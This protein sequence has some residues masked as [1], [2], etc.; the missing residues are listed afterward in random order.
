MNRQLNR[1]TIFFMI[2]LAAAMLV[3]GQDKA[4]K[5][6]T[7]SITDT[8]C[9]IGKLENNR[10][11]KCHA[12]AT[13]LENFMYGTKLSPETRFLKVKLQKKLLLH[14]WQNVSKTVKTKGKHKPLKDYFKQEI[15]DVLN[16]SRKPN[17]DIII[18]M[19][20]QN[21]LTLTKRDQDHYFSVAYALR[22]ILAL[23][24]DVMFRTDIN[25]VPL[26]Q[27]VIAPLKEFIDIFTLAVLQ[28]GDRRARLADA[29]SLTPA[30]F[31]KAWD[32][33]Q[34]SVSPQKLPA[35]DFR[36]SSKQPAP[37]PS[38]KFATTLEIINQKVKSYEA[39]N[40]ITMQV[41]LRNLQVYFARHQW[42]SDAEEGRKFR[43]FFTETM[44]SFAFEGVKYAEK[45]AKTK[46][47]GFIREEDVHEMWNSFVPFEV[48]QYEDVIFFPRLGRSGSLTIEA[49]DFDAF[50]D[51]GIHWRYLQFA[52]QDHLNELSIEPDPFAG[53]LLVEGIA[54]FGVLALRMAGMEAKAKGDKQLNTAH[55]ETAL[56]DIRQRVARHSTVKPAAKPKDI[57]ASSANVTT[58]SG[59]KT[60]FTDITQASGIGFEHRSSD[61]LSRMLRSYLK[62]S[63][64]VGTLN[65]PPAFGGAGAAA[66]DVNGDGITDVLLL[67]G[68]G[69][70]LYQGDGKGRFRDITAEAGIVFKRKDGLFGEPRQPI[71]ADFDNDGRQDILITYVQDDHKLYRNRGSGK[72]EDVSA[73]SNLGGKDLVGGPATAFDYDNDGLL[74]IYIAYF[75]DYPRGKLPKLTR[76][77]LNALP[78]KLFRNLGGMRFEDVTEK[79]GV[80]NTGWGQAL[81]H[82]DIDLDGWQDII[83]GNDFGVNVYYRNRG[84]GTFENVASQL[85]TDKPSFTM[86]V[87]ITDLNRDGFPDIYISNIVTMV[88]DEKYV[89]PAADTTMRSDP[90]KMARMRV[91]EANDLFLSHASGGK[92]ENYVLS[93]AVGRGFSSTGWAWGANFFDFD[94]DGDDDLYCVNGMNEYSVYSDTPYYTKVFKE[95][96]EIQ[97]KVYQKESNVFFVNEGG[98]LRNQSKKSGTDLLGNSRSTVYVD[99]DNDGDLDI[100]L[101][102][103]HGPAVVYRNNSQ[104]LGNNWLKVKLVGDPRRKTNRD[105]IGAKIIAYKN[106]KQL[107][108][109]EIRGGDGYLNVNPKVQHMGLGKEEVVDIKVIWPNGDEEKFKGI[110]ANQKYLIQQGSKE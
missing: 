40:K 80:G 5:K 15:A 8:I 44:V 68:S 96:R 70:A 106:D 54:Q 58:L 23:Q 83:V 52:L 82:T 35:S 1:V 62:K 81:G 79:A 24:Q 45:I 3:V 33:V 66:G 12:T 56:R 18:N 89:L 61:W 16:Y 42:P 71:I 11:P 103:Y 85:G 25:L 37:A 38:A 77:N 92:F 47:H 91:V 50:R 34:H 32:T 31:Q 17:G 46:K 57:L 88:K 76:D 59:G 101:N 7:K 14:L 20:Q 51:S 104:Q 65:V 105:A 27:A 95:K 86:N 39:Y 99:F 100:V 73:A 19:K 26:D 30:L 29:Y 107:V 55:L 102:N 90:A 48:N 64:T 67:S 87:G 93:D 13:R 41:F 22:A 2:Y 84:D 4:P 9:E 21:P 53:E 109:R 60:Y 36:A 98:I 94:N 43:N 6:D 97:L 72:F 108:W 69:N 10:D 110:K 63:E 78:N 28:E 75:G 49:Y 74:D